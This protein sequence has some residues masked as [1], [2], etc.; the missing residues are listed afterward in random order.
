[1]PPKK[2]DREER[3]L[4]TMTVQIFQ[5]IGR[6]GFGPAAAYGTVLILSVLIPK[7]LSTTL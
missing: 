6:G 5:Y 1:M 3:S 4:D 7:D 2:G